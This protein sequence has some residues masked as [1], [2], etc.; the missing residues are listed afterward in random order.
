MNLREKLNEK[1][2]PFMD[3]DELALLMKTK[4]RTLYQQIYRGTFEIPYVKNGKKVLFRTD[5]VVDWFEDNVAG[6]A[7]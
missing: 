3:L 4:R 7:A 5:Q 1:Y 6:D 2:G